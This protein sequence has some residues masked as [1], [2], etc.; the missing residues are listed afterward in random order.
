MYVH[1]NNI[2]MYIHTFIHTYVTY[3][4]SYFNIFSTNHITGV[5]SSLNMS[6]IIVLVNNSTTLANYRCVSFVRHAI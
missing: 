3:V 1:M 6:T 5:F 2:R 4:L